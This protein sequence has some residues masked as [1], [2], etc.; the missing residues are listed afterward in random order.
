[1]IPDE[2]WKQGPAVVNAKIKRLIDEHEKGEMVV[3]DPNADVATTDERDQ[4]KAAF[5]PILATRA[6]LRVVPLMASDGSASI[7]SAR[8]KT[9]LSV[10]RALAVAW[11]RTQ[12]PLLTDAQ[13]SDSA[14]RDL[15]A[16]V[17][18][19]GSATNHIGKA[20]SEAAFAAASKERKVAASRASRSLIQVRDA[21]RSAANDRVL[22]AIVEQANTHDVAEIV[23]GVRPEQFATLELWPGRDPPQFIGGQ[24]EMLKEELRL[25]DEGWDVWI[26]WYEARLDGRIREQNTELA[27]VEI[28]RNVLS[29]A[30]AWE[31]NSE[32]RRL[33]DLQSQKQPLDPPP[34]KRPEIPRPKPAA[35]EPIFKGSRLT[36]AKK[37]ADA[38]M[39][40]PTI[41][42]ALKALAQTLGALAEDAAEQSNIDKRFLVRLQEIAKAIP[43]KRPNQTEL[44]R[45]GHDYDELSAYSRTVADSWPELV[46]ARYMA[47]TR[48]F[49]RTLRRFPRWLDFTREPPIAIISA[50]DARDISQA[51]Q[52]LSAV[53]RAPENLN[54]V[55]PALPNALD[56]ISAPLDYAG[57]RHEA[58]NDP[59]ELG[60]E[61][62]ARDV[63]E[64]VNNTFKLVAELALAAKLRAAKGAEF[65]GKKL[66][67]YATEFGKHA[68]KSL[69]KSSG[70]LGDKV[71]PAIVKLAKWSLGATIGGVA[72]HAQGPT[73]AAWLVLHYPQMFAW[74]EPI[75][76]FL[77]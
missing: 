57:Q 35:V 36:L 59:I 49:E 74:L 16:H 19:S 41:S 43:K 64:S 13:L 25:A 63:L 69:L 31:A 50:Q 24:W 29:T 60:M 44:F 15:D 70:Q 71:G 4:D 75:T 42:A 34:S 45:L 76:T 77:H 27:Y 48:A 1:M 39:R 32:I 73:L 52:A 62:L 46:A 17:R 55:D 2:I 37:T 10:F 54:I 47:M 12:Y 66:R 68:D 28:T 22:E 23:P 51:A 58:R 21:A 61:L 38:D 26:D 40:G 6:A 11:A 30:S 65:A 5:T 67:S 3:D 56:S 18:G 8:S 20:A 14:A 9:V 72:V 53:L 33:I 7:D